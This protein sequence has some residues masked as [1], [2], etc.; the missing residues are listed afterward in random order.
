MAFHSSDCC[1]S[2]RVCLCLLRVPQTQA[3]AASPIS[4]EPSIRTLLKAAS[5][6]NSRCSGEHQALEPC[7]P[8]PH[9]RLRLR[10][11]LPRGSASGPFAALPTIFPDSDLK[12]S[13]ETHHC[14]IR[15]KKSP[16]PRAAFGFGFLTAGG[17]TLPGCEAS[18]HQDS[19]SVYNIA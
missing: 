1:L 17:R 11:G 3:R 12:K 8:K 19:G 9:L 6:S 15:Y 16:N 5:P 18:D 14:N 10:F 7:I 2:A 4:K 13:A